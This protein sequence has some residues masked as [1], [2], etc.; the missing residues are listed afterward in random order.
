MAKIKIGV[1]ASG[2]GS[3]LQAIIDACGKKNSAA[4]VAVVISDRADSYA[5]IRAKTRGIKAVFIDPAS[6]ASRKLHEKAIVKLLQQNK[7][8]L[9]C[10]A[11]YMRLLTGFIIGKFKNRILN[12]HPALLPAFP[13]AH[14]QKDALNYGVKVSGCTVHFV[15]E[16]MDFGPI[17][18][19]VPVLVAENDS[20]ETLAGRILKQEHKLYPKVIELFAKGKLQVK[21]RRVN[22]K[23]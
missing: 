14:G 4:E 11:G 7:A 9:V 5:L 8:D 18:A 22:I 13:G 2:R 6:Y 19:Q 1:L 20:V 16:K 12:I 17:I 15:V 3:N 10:L 21:G 23:N